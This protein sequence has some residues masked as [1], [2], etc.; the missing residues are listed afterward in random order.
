MTALGY[1]Y[2][3][4]QIHRIMEEI[5]EDGSGVIEMDEFISFMSKHMLDTENLKK[6]MT[7]IFDYFD[8]DQSGTIDEK[9]IRRMVNECFFNIDDEAISR[10]IEAADTD[11][12]GKISKY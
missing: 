4:V 9:K 1:E 12:S 6:Q 3:P 11:G 8:D 5:D 10:M 2:S 7:K